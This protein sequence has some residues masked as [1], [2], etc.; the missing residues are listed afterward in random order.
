MESSGPMLILAEAQLLVPAMTSRGA[1]QP[2]GDK[3]S[4][5]RRL[6]MEVRR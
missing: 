5:I 2:R 1:C 4:A 3:E 6:G